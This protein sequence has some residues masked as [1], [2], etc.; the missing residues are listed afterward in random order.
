MGRRDDGGLCC[1]SARPVAARALGHPYRHGLEVDHG[2]HHGSRDGGHRQNTTLRITSGIKGDT[3]I[4]PFWA[5]ERA[6]GSRCNMIMASVTRETTQTIII[7]DPVKLAKSQ[8]GSAWAAT[9]VPCMINS[10]PLTSGSKLVLQFIKPRVER[11]RNGRAT[12]WVDSAKKKA[13][14]E[15]KRR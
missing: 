2:R 11:A 8:R 14:D 9:P 7:E 4:P 5:T 6:D 15:A 12:T 3:F 10:T 1:G 13:A